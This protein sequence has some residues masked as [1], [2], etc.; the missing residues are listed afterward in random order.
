MSHFYE[1]VHLERMEY[2]LTRIVHDVVGEAV[3]L[4]ASVA[5]TA[6]PVV[7]A[8]RL[9]LP[10]HPIGEGENWGK[11]WDCAWFHV[12]GKLP[13]DWK[14]AV[15]LDLNFGGEACLFDGSGCPVYG[16]TDGSIFDS[17]YEKSF[18]PAFPDVRGG[19][20]I[21]LWVEAGANKI[22][23]VTPCFEPKWIDGDPSRLHGRYVSNLVR[24][25]ACRWNEDAYGYWRD[26]LVLQSLMQSLKEQPSRRLAVLRIID[27]SL[28]VR[29]T[30][31]YGAAR[32]IVSEAWELD[33][34]PAAMDV[35]GVGHAHIDTAWLWPMRETVRKCARTF[36]SQIHLIEHD[37][38]FIFGASQAQLYAFTKE[39]YPALYEKIRKAI[40]GGRWEAQ[41]AMWVEA[42][43]NIPSGESLVR[44]ILVGKNFFRDE[45]GVD[46]KNLWLP[47]VF[48]YSGNLPQIL[49]RAGVDYFLTQK[50]SWN[51]Y[52]KFPHNTFWWRGIDGSAVLSHFPP[53][54]T[55]NSQ[56]LPASLKLHET[57]NSEA[58]L[59]KE[60]LCL[61]GIGDGGGGPSENFLANAHRAEHLNGCPRF[62]FGKA[63]PVLEKLASYGD[64][65]DTW[66][67]ELYFEFHRG[68][69]TSQAG[70]KRWNR[71]AEEAFRSTEMILSLAGADR[72]PAEEML[73][74]WKR[75]LV[76]QFH[77]IIPGSSINRVYAE[78]VPEIRRVI[79]RLGSLA[80]SAAEHLLSEEADAVTY[81][82]P[83][84][85][86]CRGTG[87][88]P[89]GWRAATA[90]GETVPAQVEE[91]GEVVVSLEIPPRSFS[92][93]RRSAHD[94]PPVSVVRREPDG[95]VVLE[96]DRVRYLFDA[97]TMALREVYDKEAHRLVIG[98][99]AFANRVETFH[100][101]PGN[102][103]ETFHG[104]PFTY[105]AWDI[106]EYILDMKMDSLEVRSLRLV[107]GAVRDGV[108]VD[109]RIGGSDFRQAIWLEKGGKRLDFVTDVDW[110]EDHK[111]LR[112]AF[113]TNLRSQEA[114][115]E[116][117]YGNV[118]RPTNDNTK[119]QH[120]QFEAIGHRYADLSEPDCGLALLNDSKYGYRVK[121]GEL[122]LSLLRA[123]T[124]PD[125]V[126]DRGAQ[127]F[128]YSLLPHASDLVRS[129]VLEHAAILNQGVT[130]FPGRSDE[131][132]LRFPVACD[133]KVDLA[134]LKR[135]EK[136]SCLVVRFV[137][138]RGL[139]VFSEIR[140][141]PGYRLVETDLMEWADKG[142]VD[143]GAPLEFP[144]FSIRTF[145]ILPE[146]K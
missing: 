93:L 128:V 24:C 18:Y 102:R 44:Q 70:I 129:D 49:R 99:T 88:L 23:G 50:L 11:T 35:Y 46:I 141:A 101:I 124:F 63:Q 73:A 14:G 123:P 61:F 112:V 32:E 16:L 72:Y 131:T 142:E 74:L 98:P 48:G 118:A 109:A 96:N 84:S 3:P 62:H 55:Y 90:R 104:S 137:E 19:E 100:D 33:T 29:A 86:T 58:G 66:D 114:R 120:A 8:K 42:D 31:G 138:P 53:E 39:N 71:R 15:V 56:V 47:D 34:D 30:D 135:A 22:N 21:D 108:L 133:E 17:D 67:G 132:G 127:H 130:V 76:N 105:D 106:D 140:L 107:R 145:K 116:I 25:R 87:R 139:H 37:P 54:D 12:T 134:V 38:D 28:D 80:S 125:P 110:Q 91:D 51:F 27:R 57:N 60:G 7:F 82:N 4:Q 83:S 65:L 13:A 9:D 144:P 146:R 122:S 45:F 41:G 40:A 117:Q 78:Q 2:A 111:L 79:D 94:V 143:C 85:T 77:D 26:L 1:K 5:V 113:P 92:T 10:F 115:Y 36:S 75:F 95:E 119:W 121:D 59:V 69:Y 103:V 43:C 52:N 81:F 20:P 126:A 97:K 68:T 89:E 64:E 136:E 6:E